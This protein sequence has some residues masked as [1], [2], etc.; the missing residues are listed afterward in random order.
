MKV[1][2][3]NLFSHPRGGI[4]AS[5]INA[6]ARIV[7]AIG[8][9]ETA[10]CCP[11]SA[12]RKALDVVGFGAILLSGPDGVECVKSF[13]LGMRCRVSPNGRG[14]VEEGPRGEDNL[15]AMLGWLVHARDYV[16][17]VVK[18]ENAMIMMGRP[19]VYDTLAMID[20]DPVLHTWIGGVAEVYVEVWKNRR[21]AELSSRAAAAQHVETLV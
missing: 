12:Q 14:L 18:V 11:D 7:W 19:P 20:V 21:H 1:F 4:K 9:V 15:H 3:L 5:A 8:E 10:L 2:T 6:L 16:G 17:W 13:E